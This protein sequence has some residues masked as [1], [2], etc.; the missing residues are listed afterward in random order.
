MLSNLAA[1]Y[2]NGN[3][4]AY[5]TLLSDHAIFTGF[6]IITNEMDCST[7]SYKRLPAYQHFDFFPKK[8]NPRLHV[9]RFI[10][11]MLQPIFGDA[12]VGEISL[13]KDTIPATPI[14]SFRKGMI[15]ILE[16]LFSLHRLQ[17]A[18]T[19][20]DP[21][22]IIKTPDRLIRSLRGGTRALFL[23]RDDEIDFMFCDY[24]IN[25]SAL[26]GW[27][28]AKDYELLNYNVVGKVITFNTDYKH[29]FKHLNPNRHFKFIQ[30]E[31]NMRDYRF[32][33]HTDIR[34][35]MHSNGDIVSVN[36]IPLFERLDDLWRLIPHQT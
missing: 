34:L 8:Q 4:N 32:K 19:F 33:Q 29:K 2:E 14:T 36:G 24:S 13:G 30:N 27:Y 12:L 10:R 35:N 15:G 9:D 20:T 26:D 28:M 3:F 21:I 31:D 6:D 18:S 25:S 23:D 11:N 7:T 5:Q 17:A 22:V 1:Y 16:K